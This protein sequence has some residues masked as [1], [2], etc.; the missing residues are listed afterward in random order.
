MLVLFLFFGA[1]GVVGNLL[2]GLFRALKGGL[3]GFGGGQT[4]ESERSEQMNRNGQ[5]SNGVRRMKRFK[6]WA[7][8]T[9]FEESAPESVE[10]E[11]PLFEKMTNK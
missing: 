4:S 5:S 2:G 7:E 9:S 8:D 3:S 1:I 11:E 10:L 6:S